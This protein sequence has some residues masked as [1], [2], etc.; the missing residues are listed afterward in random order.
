MNPVGLLRRLLKK[1]RFR[2]D[3]PECACLNREEAEASINAAG[4]RMYV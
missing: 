1:K 3:C 4:S 2:N